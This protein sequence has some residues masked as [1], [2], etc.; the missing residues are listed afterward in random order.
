MSFIGLNFLSQTVLLLAPERLACG[1]LSQRS[2]RA[3]AANDL[4]E[5]ETMHFLSQ[6]SECLP[7]AFEITAERD[8]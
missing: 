1:L 2:L 3:I 7:Q 8:R 4:T 6:S 5:V